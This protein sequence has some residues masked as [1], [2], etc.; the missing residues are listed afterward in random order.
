M[1]TDTTCNFASAE[2]VTFAELA[3]SCWA[4]LLSGPQQKK[5]K[6]DLEGGSWCRRSL[7][8]S[9]RAQYCGCNLP[10][11]G[12]LQKGH[13]MQ[14]EVQLVLLVEGGPLQLTDVNRYSFYHS[15]PVLG[16]LIT[17]H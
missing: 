14:Q 11:P 4:L 15:V 16:L 13:S 10:D 2:N 1:Q 17:S 8:A 9:P 12:S 5:G 7:A 3:A 6:M